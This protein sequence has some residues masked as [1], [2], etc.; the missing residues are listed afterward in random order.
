MKARKGLQQEDER[1]ADEVKDRLKDLE[2]ND[3]HKHDLHSGFADNRG[4]GD[5]L[6]ISPGSDVFCVGHKLA[7]TCLKGTAFTMTSMVTA[8]A[9]TMAFVAKQ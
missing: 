1:R 3:R 2:R 8:K 9:M 6:R 5:F 7:I 4:P